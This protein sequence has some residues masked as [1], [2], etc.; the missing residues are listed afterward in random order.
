MTAN[1]SSE[2]FVDKALACASTALQAL[3]NGR[4]IDANDL[5]AGALACD[6]LAQGEAHDARAL[7]LGRELRSLARL[8]PNL[9]NLP[10][11]RRL[12]GY[13]A[14]IAE[15]MEQLRHA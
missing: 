10:P 12:P 3:L 14:S 15:S 4:S 6:Q 11:H 1:P 2:S 9:G 13:V 8:V 7:E 5:I